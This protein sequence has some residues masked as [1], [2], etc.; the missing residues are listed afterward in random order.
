LKIFAK[1]LRFLE[2]R[3]LNGKLAKFC[4]ERIHHD[5]DRRVAF[6]FSEIWPTGNRLVVCYLPDKKTSPGSPLSLLRGLRPK[7]ATDSPQQCTQTAPNFIQIGSRSWS[8]TR[9]REHRQN[10]L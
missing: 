2:K 6:K 10:G 4:S 5:I 9:T 7:S 3:L 8:Y 1:I